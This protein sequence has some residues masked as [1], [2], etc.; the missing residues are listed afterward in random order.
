MH[1]HTYILHK[2]MQARTQ[3]FLQGVRFSPPHPFCGRSEGPLKRSI[4]RAPKVPTIGQKSP[5]WAKIAQTGCFLGNF[6]ELQGGEGVVTP[7]EMLK[8]VLRLI[9]PPPQ[10]KPFVLII[11]LLLCNVSIPCRRGRGFSNLFYLRGIHLLHNRNLNPL[12]WTGTGIKGWGI[13]SSES[14]I[15]NKG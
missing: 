8:G 15:L 9:P 3:D 14:E 6:A 7:H 1:I 2:K 11:T 12:W 10:L 13:I 4:F 5:K